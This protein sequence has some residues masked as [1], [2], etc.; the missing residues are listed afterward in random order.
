MTVSTEVSDQRGFLKI[1]ITGAASVANAGQG[2]VLNPEGVRLAIIRSYAY[3][4]TGSTGA[5][6]LDVGIGATGTK[7]TDILSTFDVIQ[8]TVG[9]KAFYCQAVPANE[10]EEA[11]IWEVGEYVTFT[12]SATMVG[13]AGDLYLEYIRLA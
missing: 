13:L 3:F 2:Q 11:V 6:N 4:A 12:A 1:A 10:T 5:C 9:A 8:A 7:N